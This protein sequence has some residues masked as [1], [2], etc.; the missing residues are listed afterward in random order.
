VRATGGYIGLHSGGHLAGFG[1]YFRHHTGAWMTGQA[2]ILMALT[3]IG[4]GDGCTVVVPGSH[5]SNLVHPHYNAEGADPN[6][7]VNYTGPAAEADGVVEVHLKA[8][9]ALLFT[10]GLAHGSSARR[11]PGQRRTLLYRYC[12]AWIMP[13]WN[14][15]ASPELVSRLTEARRKIVQPT[16]PRL[17]PG[18]RTAY[19]AF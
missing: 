8:G 6:K 5:R 2:N 14:Y 11:N 9:D 15:I 1:S 4:P 3:D 12:A 17:T 7:I 19:R 13:R 10:D 16:P 18:V